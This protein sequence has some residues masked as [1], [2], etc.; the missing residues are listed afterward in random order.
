MS[1]QRRGQ[2]KIQE[3]AFVLV[4]LMIFFALVA[5]FYLSVRG[6][7]LEQRVQ[8]QS[9]EHAMEAVRQ[10][11]AT[12]EFTWSECKGCI[13]LDK[14]FILKNQI[15][16]GA[17]VEALKDYDYLVVETMY[18]AREGGECTPAIYPAC[19]RTS[20]VTSSASYG[21]AVSSF[22]TVCR[23]DSEEQR[24][25]ELGRLYVSDRRRERAS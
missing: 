13:D 16:R 25:C 8:D 11:A 22:V 3:M 18:P 14:V 2:M 19:N 9:D 15:A 21:I 10:L 1:C 7:M 23:W 17:R 24:V 6:G 12:P 20:V 5:V 4:A